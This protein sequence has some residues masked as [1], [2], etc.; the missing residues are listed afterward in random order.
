LETPQQRRLAARRIPE[1]PRDHTGTVPRCILVEASVP[2]IDM[3]RCTAM[4]W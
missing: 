2:E 3:P 1:L 4:P